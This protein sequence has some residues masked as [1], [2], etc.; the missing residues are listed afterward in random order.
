MK[1]RKLVL[2][3]SI[4]MVFALC[5]E[6]AADSKTDKKRSH[7]VQIGSSKIYL[8][9]SMRADVEKNLGISEK[10]EFFKHGGEDFNWSNFTVCTYTGDK[11]RFHYNEDGYVIRITVSSQY[12]AEVTV[13]EGLLS[14]LNYDILNKD[15]EGKTEVYMNDKFITWTEYES[16]TLVVHPSYWFNDQKKV[17]WFDIYYMPWKSWGNRR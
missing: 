8:G 11:L 2:L 7:H 12:P 3:I 1:K 9:Y 6:S 5:I 15:V 4:C 13:P 16:P 14:E 10:S 17:M